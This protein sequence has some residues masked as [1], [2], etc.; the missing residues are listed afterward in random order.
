[1]MM[2]MMLSCID[3]GLFALLLII[4]EDDVDA[5]ENGRRIRA[6]VDY[7]DNC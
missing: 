1:M 5:W 7:I 4:D 6:R 3:E 2:M